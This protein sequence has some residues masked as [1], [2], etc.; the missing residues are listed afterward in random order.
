MYEGDIKEIGLGYD[1]KSSE[2]EKNWL[3]IKKKGERDEER[4]LGR[5]EQLRFKVMCEWEVNEEY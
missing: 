4:V 1:R 3:D 5:E 2:L